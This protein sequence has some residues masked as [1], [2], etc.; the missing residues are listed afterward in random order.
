MLDIKARVLCIPNTHSTMEPHLFLI[1]LFSH[2]YSFFFL[3]GGG[4]EEEDLFQLTVQHHSL[5]LR[6]ITAEVNAEATEECYLVACSPWLAQ[7][8]LLNP[9]SPAQG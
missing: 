6:E 8:F 3:S 9:G 4:G 5:S 1:V 7:S 2:L